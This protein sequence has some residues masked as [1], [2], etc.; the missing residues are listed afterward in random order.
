M[1]RDLHV[2]ELAGHPGRALHDPAALHHAAAEPGAD[3]R[4]HRGAPLRLRAEVQ[5][6]RVQRG[7]VG[8]VGVDH[9]QPELGRER[10]ADVEAAPLGLVEVRRA[11]GGDDPVRAGRPGRVQPDRDDRVAR[12]PGPA[13]S[14]PSNACRSASSAAPVPRAPGSASRTGRRPGTGRSRRGRWRWCEVPPM[15]RPTTTPGLADDAGDMT[16]SLRVPAGRPAGRPERSLAGRTRS[17]QP[18]PPDPRPTAGPEPPSRPPSGGS[19]YGRAQLLRYAVRLSSVRR[20]AGPSLVGVVPTADADVRVRDG[21]TLRTTSPSGPPRRHRAR[22]RRQSGHERSSRGSP[23]E[24]RAAGRAGDSGAGQHA[25][26]WP[27]PVSGRAGASPNVLDRTLRT[28]LGAE[29]SP[30]RYRTVP[31][32]P[33]ASPSGFRPTVRPGVVSRPDPLA[34]MRVDARTSSR[35]GVSPVIAPVPVGAA[36]TKRPSRRLP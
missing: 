24:D 28:G 31:R 1:H 6:V 11:L 36:M 15:S 23:G 13:S 4:G 14:T 9:R 29:L 18:P 8:V 3:D 35:L 5:V 17:S 12:Q 10:A 34:R 2:A 22:R 32:P 7:R 30:V 16:T 26:T 33:A 27:L 25:T 21:G 19:R 20:T